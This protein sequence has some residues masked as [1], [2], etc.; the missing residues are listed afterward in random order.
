MFAAT[1]Q[2]A[3]GV[4]VKD[5]VRGSVYDALECR[6][7]CKM[8]LR[9]QFCPLAGDDCNSQENKLPDVHTGKAVA[10]L[11]R[12]ADWSDKEQGSKA[13]KPLATSNRAVPLK[14]AASANNANSKPAAAAGPSKPVLKQQVPQAQAPQQQPA[15]GAGAKQQQGLAVAES[16]GL[17]AGSRQPQQWQ[18]S[19]FDIGRPLGR[20]KFGNVYLAREKKSNFI[21]ALKVSISTVVDLLMLPQ[22]QQPQNTLH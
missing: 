1:K 22:E 7:F 20:G 2:R 13:M 11:K 9:T 3:G 10:S 16:A 17:T 6:E 15:A 19:D 14:Q 12:P 21:V 8:P 5:K 4:A 18:L